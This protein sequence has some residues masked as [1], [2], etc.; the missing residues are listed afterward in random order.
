MLV[1]YSEKLFK[2]KEMVLIFI[3]LNYRKVNYKGKFELKKKVFE[4]T[5]FIAFYAVKGVNTRLYSFKR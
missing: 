3:D 1:K 4:K 5:T 2:K